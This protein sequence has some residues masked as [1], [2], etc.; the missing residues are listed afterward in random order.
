MED[1][2]DRSMRRSSSATEDEGSTNIT[3]P[4]TPDN[5]I[6]AQRYKLTIRFKLD[7]SRVKTNVDVFFRQRAL[8]IINQQSMRLFNRSQGQE[9]DGSG[10][11]DGEQTL[12]LSVSRDTDG[13]VIIMIN[14][15]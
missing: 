10:S 6:E 13:Q 8:Q 7:N 12:D 4:K 1:G 9:E 15:L 3:P 11:D 5:D 14:G 2:T